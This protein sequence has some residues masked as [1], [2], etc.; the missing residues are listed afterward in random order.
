MLQKHFILLIVFIST[1]LFSGCYTTLQTVKYYHVYSEDDSVMTEQE[2]DVETDQVIVEHY[3]YP[4]R[5]FWYDPWYYEPG[6]YVSI[7]YY[8]WPYYADP[9]CP[10]YP[11]WY[12][13]PVRY[14]YPAYYHHPYYYDY[15]DPIYHHRAYYRDIDKRPFKRRGSNIATREDKRRSSRDN[16]SIRKSSGHSASGST[17]VAVRTGG[18]NIRKSI[19]PSSVKR[20]RSS[21]K[22]NSST[23]GSKQ[24]SGNNRVNR[25]KGTVHKVRTAKKNSKTSS[26]KT[27]SRAVTR[28][29]KAVE[30]S[31]TG[32]NRKSQINNK[33]SSSS[34]GY[35]KSRSTSAS[36]VRS[37]KSNT[38][39]RS[40]SSSYN[41]SSKRSTAKSSSGSRKSTP[42]RGR[43]R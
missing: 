39:S 19:K 30:S 41:S 14:Y 34:S 18:N 31:S 16:P 7:D 10:P 42:S 5:I 4:G 27:V 1:F 22:N 28:I 37:S 29:K 21:V 26:T 36:K 40:S 15:Y 9:F 12:C 11:G 8:D 13:P 2:Y 17:S 6:F 3:Y 25:E 24:Q 38:N 43:R 23:G 20:R 35:T 32:S 33:E